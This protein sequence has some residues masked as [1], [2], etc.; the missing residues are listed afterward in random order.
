M[1]HYENTKKISREFAI[2]LDTSRSAVIAGN[3]G[4]L[5]VSNSGVSDSLMVSSFMIYELS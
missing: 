5:V 1:P 2:G 3:K 4:V